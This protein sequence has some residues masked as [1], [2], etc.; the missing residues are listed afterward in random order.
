MSIF[1]L[2]MYLPLLFC[3]VFI[4]VAVD[5]VTMILPVDSQPPMVSR[6]KQ[7]VVLEGG[8]T[9]LTSRQLT[10]TDP[11]TRDSDVTCSVDVQPTVGFL[12]N[13]TPSS[14]SEIS[15]AEKRVTSFTIDDIRAGR[16]SYVQDVYEGSEPTMDW[17]AFS[18]SDGNNTSPRYLLNIDII[19]Q[20]DEKPQIFTRDFYVDEGDEKFIDV[21]VL[22]AVD[23]D[24]PLDELVFFV[25]TPPRHGMITDRR[26]GA[27][28]PVPRF[29]LTQIKKSTSIVYQHDGS[30]STHDSFTLSVS[31]GKFNTTRSIPVIITPVDD[32]EPTLS[33]NAGLR[34]ASVGESKTITPNNLK[35]Q[36]V[37]SLDENI[38]FV[39]R[40]PPRA[41]FLR[42]INVN[43]SVQ[44]LAQWQRFTQRDIDQRRIVYSQDANIP[45][46]RDMI[47]FDLSDGKNTRLN[48]DFYV[49]ISAGDRIHPTVINKGVRLA[50]DSRMIIST[51]FLSASDAGSANEKLRYFLVKQPQKGRLE[52]LDFPGVRLD[53]FTQ[54]DMAGNKILYIHTSSDEATA[55]S[56]DFEV[57]DGTN[58]VVRTFLVTL[59]NIDNKKPVLIHNKLVVNEGE[60]V[61]ITPF[62]L[63]AEDQD[64]KPGN[65]VYTVTRVPL[66]GWLLNSGMP[67]RMFT[68][69][70]IN[71]NRISYAHDGTDVDKDSFQIKVSDG[72]HNEFY[73]FPDTESLV[74]EPREIHVVVV[75]VDNRIP[76]LVLNQGATN[77]ETLPCNRIGLVIRSSA[78]RVEDLDS[79]NS[80]LLYTVTYPPVNGMLIREGRYNSNKSVTNFTQS[81]INVGNISYVLHNGRSATNDAFDFDVSDPAGNTL[82]FQR[83]SLT[84]AWVSFERQ[85]HQVNE[86]DGVLRF[87]IVRRG[88]LGDPSSVRMSVKGRTATQGQ[89]F[90]LAG[91]AHV[92]FS[93]GQSRAEWKLYVQ[94]DGNYEGNETLE[95]ELTSP[96][97]CVIRQPRTAQVTITDPEDGMN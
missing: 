34:I 95:V 61:L 44:I 76:Q 70:D 71:L 87:V 19:P 4:F 26:K 43:G 9:K 80:E 73:V 45:S 21:T 28:K 93:P 31:D 74:R 42:R 6:I 94:D 35:A 46:E 51:N 47:K 8:K 52:H 22:N 39:V 23:N 48:Q 65:L 53:S 84:W 17:V 11:D 77:L 20:N 37:D 72:T 58:G 16:I 82:R 3:F 97:M 38:M 85:K 15:N 49:E 10:I 60:N 57:S 12:E 50:Q 32:E 36:D 13:V 67:T 69:E 40:S 55:D 18:C 63:R 56:F 5:V 75:P 33:V 54:L 68:Q 66:H 91:P 88:F 90:L 24:E 62:E 2:L 30:E 89:D 78:L 1:R 29:S 92:Q 14:G 81:D 64:T 7:L 79:N 83:F 96:Q 27:T 41:G 86:T 25:V 59:I